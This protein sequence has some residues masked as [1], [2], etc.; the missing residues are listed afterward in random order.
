MTAHIEREENYAVPARRRTLDA[1]TLAAI[2]REMAARRGVDA[3][4]LPRQE[5]SAA[6]VRFLQ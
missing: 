1:A 3:E 5:V 6:H 2:G 4:A